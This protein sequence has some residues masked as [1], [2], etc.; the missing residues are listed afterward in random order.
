MSKVKAEEFVAYLTDHPEFMEK[1]K[2]FTM[3]ELKEAI[4]DSKRS[5]L[6]TSEDIVGGTY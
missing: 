5:G 3:E 1:I 6:L 2:G 4:D